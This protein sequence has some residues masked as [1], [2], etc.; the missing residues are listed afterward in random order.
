MPSLQIF[1]ISFVL[2]SR[3]GLSG[4]SLL[5]S[6]VCFQVSNHVLPTQL[7]WRQVSAK[8]SAR[9]L[10]LGADYV[11]G[12][13]ICI[14]GVIKRQDA[15]TRNTTPFSACFRLRLIPAGRHLDTPSTLDI[16]LAPASVPIFERRS[17]LHH[18]DR[19]ELLPRA[20]SSLGEQHSDQRERFPILYSTRGKV[21]RGTKIRDREF[22]YPRSWR[23]LSVH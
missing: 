10:N 16:P 4:A 22:H 1:P 19:W 21:R 9:R 12:P 8:Y 2:C 23:L 7:A 13:N 3:S 18:H 14:L 11:W 15:N 17:H 6:L 5:L 20:I